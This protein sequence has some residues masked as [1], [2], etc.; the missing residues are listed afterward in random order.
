L[1]RKRKNSSDGVFSLSQEPLCI[2]YLQEFEVLVVVAFVDCLIDL[3]Y[4]FE[5]NY[6]VITTLDW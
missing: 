5:L 1:F 6:F 3:T 2:N 4:I